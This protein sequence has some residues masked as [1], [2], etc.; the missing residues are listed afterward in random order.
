MAHTGQLTS[1]MVSVARLLR[2][3][4]AAWRPRKGRTSLPQNL[5]AVVEGMTDGFFAVNPDWVITYVNR[6]A[7]VVLGRPRQE[8]IGKQLWQL[9]PDAWDSVFGREYRLAMAEGAQREFESYSQAQGRWFS[10]H[11]LPSSEGLAVYFQDVSDRRRAEN[12]LRESEQRYRA[13]FDQSMDAVLLAV[14][15]GRIRMVNRSACELLGYDESE[16]VQLRREDLVD[17]SD[18]DVQAAMQT[19]RER[20]HFR[21]TVPMRRKDGSA[22]R[23]EISSSVFYDQHSVEWISMFVRDV[24]ERERQAQERERLVKQIEAE[25]AWLDTILRH[26]PLGAI[27]V[28]ADG[29]VQF[30]AHAERLFGLQLSPERGSGQYANLLL[31]PDGRPVPREEMVSARV[32]RTGESVLGAEFLVQR[33]DGT[34]FPILGSAAAIRQPDGTIVAGVGM[35]QDVSEWMAAEQKVRANELLLS[36]IFDVLP[37]GLSIADG[38]GRYVRHNAALERSLTRLPE[39]VQH[40]PA[41]SARW[42]D[43]DHQIESEKWPPLRALRNGES[44]YGKLLR[45]DLDESRTLVLSQ[46][47]IPLR[48]EHGQIDGVLVAYEDVT[49]LKSSEEA[50]RDAVRAREEVMSVVAHDLRNPL[51]GVAITTELMKRRILRGQSVSAETTDNVLASLRRMNMLIGDLLDAARLDAGTLTVKSERVDPTPLVTELFESQKLALQAAGLQLVLELEPSLPAI[52]AEPHRLLQVLENLISNAAKFTPAGGTVRIRAASGD[53]VH[54]SVQDTGCGIASEHL[55]R[56]FDRYWQVNR[57]D[58]RGAG[59]GLAISKGIV[60]AHGGKLWVESALGSGTT[61]HFT[62][63]SFEGSSPVLA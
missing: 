63:P 30:N 11:A 29:T 58:K 14:S 41:R 5:L 55:P 8:L 60:E 22:F 3:S 20:G 4:L 1:S 50:L 27:I 53:S 38:Q 9:F 35:F 7:E 57:A 13:L 49:A 24:S 62:I 48:D 25:R 59:L 31:Y 42:A 32:M 34:R 6:R 21:G 40:I 12:A 23:A 46:S 28:R 56:L 54:F 43:S 17:E 37:V 18:P 16:L 26:V 61:F 36:G 19:R 47:A 44:S 15:D 45:L 33:P 39:H 2:G 52:R 10:V 51:N